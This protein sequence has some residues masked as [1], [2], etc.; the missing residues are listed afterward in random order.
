[1]LECLL[2]ICLGVSYGIYS[3]VLSRTISSFLRNLQIDFQS[4]VQVCTL[5]SNEEVF[6]LFHILASMCYLLSTSER[7][8]I[9]KI[10]KELTKVRD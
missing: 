3:W 2:S 9:T 5:T 8:L 10:Y 1:M 6:P 4:G 7:G